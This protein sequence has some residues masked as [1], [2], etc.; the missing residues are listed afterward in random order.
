MVTH[1][2]FSLIELMVIVVIVTM[3]SATALPF[4]KTYLVRSQ[5]YGGMLLLDQ[6]RKSV[7]QYWDTHG[8]MPNSSNIPNISNPTSLIAEVVL[9]NNNGA[10]GVEVV[11]LH[12][13]F[14]PAADSHLAGNSIF[15]EGKNQDGVW[16]WLCR[17][18]VGDLVIDNKYLPKTCQFTGS[19]PDLFCLD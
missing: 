4:Y 5:V 15:L 1:A 18:S 8:Q 10:N 11:K 2:A 16:I 9:E 12:V 3:I 7:I 17:H 6:H 19:C 14:S 13:L